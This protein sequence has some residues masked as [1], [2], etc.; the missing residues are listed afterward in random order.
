MEPVIMAAYIEGVATVCA[1]LLAAIAAAVI[2][3]KFSQGKKLEDRLKEAQADI[4]FLLAVE[5]EHCELH[6]D[7]SGESNKN[8]IRKVVQQER[9]LFWSGENTWS[10]LR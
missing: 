4:A 1:A 8:R 9:G 10:R 3:R 6:K 7:N 5:Q 2:G